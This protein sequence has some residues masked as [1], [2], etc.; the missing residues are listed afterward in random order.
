MAFGRLTTPVALRERQEILRTYFPRRRHRRALIER[1]VVLLVVSVVIATLGLWRDSAAVVIAAMLVAPLLVPIVGLS[2]AVVMGWLRA[3]LLLLMLLILSSAFAC[4]VGYLVIAA[5]APP[6]DI[7]LTGQI[8]A[9][10]EPTFEDLLVAACAGF[11]AAFAHLRR[12]GAGAVQG[13]AIAVALV[14]PLAAASVL[15][16]Q[17]QWTP[18]LNALLLFATNVATVVLIAAV[19]FL[20]MGFRTGRHR[21][22]SIRPILGSTLAVFAV[23]VVV[24]IPLLERTRAIIVE[25]REEVRTKDAV[26]SYLVDVDLLID[27][28]E[29]EG[30]VV[31]LELRSVLPLEEFTNPNLWVVGGREAVD[32]ELEELQRIVSAELGRPMILDI[33]WDVDAKER[34]R[35][36]GDWR[37]R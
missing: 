33:T 18:A 19:T 29:I 5:F 15:F 14:P 10:T 7:E 2:L 23:V 3:Q 28:I 6:D 25:L 37:E 16:Y 1:F 27:R 11:I 9:R 30:D 31:F 4:L 22:S 12:E 34:V 17:N 13:A 26:R 32:R 8:L 20:L 24:A 36:P 35:P 21:G